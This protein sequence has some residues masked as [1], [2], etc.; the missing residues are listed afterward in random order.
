M[1]NK[2][3][4]L[5]W[6]PECYPMMSID[7]KGDPEYYWKEMYRGEWFFMALIWAIEGKLKGA[8]CVRIN[9]R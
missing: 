9:W 4:V 3:E 2:Y 7:E 1:G 5:A 6:M 8:G